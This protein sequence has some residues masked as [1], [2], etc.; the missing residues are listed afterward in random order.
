[1]SCTEP[2]KQAVFSCDGRRV[3]RADAAH[4][5][6]LLPRRVGGRRRR[7]SPLR[8]IPVYA[9]AKGVKSRTVLQAVRI[10]A[11]RA[12]RVPDPLPTE[13]RARR[14]L[15]GLAARCRAIHRPA[16]GRGLAGRR[17]TG[18]VSRRRSSSRWPSPS[19]ARQTGWSPRPRGGPSPAASSRRSTPGCRSSSR[20]A[21][22]RS[23]TRSPPT[24]PRTGP[25]SACCRARSAR[26]RPWWRCGP[27]SPWS[28]RARRRPCWRRPRSSPRSTTGPSA[29][30]SGR[31]ASGGM[32]GGRR[33]TRPGSPC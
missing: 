6:G 7:S 14:G 29:R 27:C 1:M 2:G 25:C 30:C 24:W 9:Q 26:A 5:S 28:T 4:T 31:S 18:S 8:R 22:A 12:R 11:R 16:R 32:L 10:A 23:P 13:I 3:P 21:S 20:A 15:I 17:G 33:A 19:D